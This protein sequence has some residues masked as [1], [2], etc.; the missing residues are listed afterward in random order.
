MPTVILTV[1]TPD[2]CVEMLDDGT[3]RVTWEA[4]QPPDPQEPPPNEGEEA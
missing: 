3:E 2:R 1:M 4:P